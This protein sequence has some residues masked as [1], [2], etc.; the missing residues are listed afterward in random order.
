M[1]HV[2][3]ASASPRVGTVA[4]G[5]AVVAQRVVTVLLDVVTGRPELPT[6]QLRPVGPA[7]GRGCVPTRAEALA[8]D[9]LEREPEVLREQ[10]VDQRVDRAVAVPQPKQDREHQRMDAVLAERH[11]QVHREE[12]QPTKNESPNDNPQC[13]RRFGLHAKPF[14]LR[15]DVPLTHP[16]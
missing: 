7:S 4:T 14:H 15:L 12:R 13:L 16:L 1:R 3:L 2:P 5:V 11:H 8:N 10:R 6:L 9:P